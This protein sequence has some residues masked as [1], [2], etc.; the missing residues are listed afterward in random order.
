MCGRFGFYFNV[1]EEYLERKIIGRGFND[2]VYVCP[3]FMGR[4]EMG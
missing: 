2:L 3:Y 1:E 4:M